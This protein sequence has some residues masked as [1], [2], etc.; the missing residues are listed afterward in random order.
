MLKLA[1]NA[2]FFLFLPLILVLF[3]AAACAAAEPQVIE[4]EVIKEVEKIV[5]VEVEKEV[6]KIVEVIN[7][8]VK[9]VVVVATPV[10]GVFKT[11]LPN[12]V[13]IGADHHYMA[14]LHSSTGPILG[15]WTS[16]TGP[17]QPQRY[18]LRALVSTR[19]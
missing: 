16:I 13:S 5:E 12:W 18:C 10:P 11:E 15:F 1:R 9:E 2:R 8:T 3:F 17:V 14:R 4:K 6:Q 19:F 7:E